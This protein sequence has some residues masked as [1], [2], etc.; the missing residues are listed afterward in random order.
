MSYCASITE[1]TDEVVPG[2]VGTGGGGGGGGGQGGTGQPPSFQKTQ[3]VPFLWW[4]SDLSLR[5][6][7]CPQNNLQ[8]L[9][10]VPSINCVHKTN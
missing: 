10:K 6:K 5:E 8:F 7:C 9:R 4:Q 3:K 2:G 1:Q